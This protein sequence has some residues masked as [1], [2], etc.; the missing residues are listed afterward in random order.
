[1]LDRA[2]VRRTFGLIVAMYVL[3]AALAAAQLLPAIDAARESLRAGASEY[4][5]ASTY[6]LPPE[7]LL[8]LIVPYPFGDDFSAPYTGQW[9]MW[10]MSLYVGGVAVVLALCA[11]I[12]P[13]RR[14]HV[15]LVIVL[16]LAVLLAVGGHTP[17]F[18]A[19]YELVPG[20][21]RFRAPARFAFLAAL[22]IAALAAAGFDALRDVRFRRRTVATIAA[23]IAA[24]LLAMSLVTTSVRQLPGVAM[25]FAQL[26]VIQP[27]L[28]RWRQ[29]AYVIP[30]LL[31]F[32]LWR[33]AARTIEW[34]RPRPPPPS[35]ATTIAPDERVITVSERFFNVPTQLR[36][37]D[38]WGY[39]PATAA[40]WVDLL[41]PLL[42]AD[43]RRGDFTPTRDLSE[44]RD[45]P[46]WP[47]L[48]VRRP[49][50][51]TTQ[52]WNIDP[53]PRV[54]LLTNCEVVDGPAASLAAVRAA[55]FDPRRKL[56][57]ESA[58]DPAPQ[59]GDGDPGVARVVARTADSLTIDADLARPAILLITDAYSAGWHAD[60][61]YRVMPA[62]H[63]LRAIAL[64]AGRHHIVMRYRPTSV[65]VGMLVSIVAIVASVAVGVIRLTLFRSRRTLSASSSEVVV[66]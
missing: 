30:L 26:A 5:F 19:I 32:E 60:P 61:P 14:R 35:L 40:R 18:R 62:N 49:V 63:A 22:T 65:R 54:M 66:P 42:G 33:P 3:G 31:L 24:L 29:V 13:N 27:L 58:P 6:S 37:E 10:E 57:L 17:L 12:A 39:D 25:V 52:P 9:L 20:F 38:A 48:R 50:P 2:G 1:M 11:L 44:T 43:A 21:G 55:N 15:P 28:G 64:P 36:I 53:L 56:I 8:T 4:A 51:P 59:T 34:F 45:S 7:N 47:M 41:A 46:I 16:V 23:V